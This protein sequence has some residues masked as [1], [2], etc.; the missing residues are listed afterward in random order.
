MGA[1]RTDG[2]GED[3]RLI[4]TLSDTLQNAGVGLNQ[5]IVD[6]YMELV[7]NYGLPAVLAGIQSAVENNKQH[8]F[9]Y[10]AACVA[11]AATGNRPVFAPPNGA[12]PTPPP[13]ER[14]LDFNWEDV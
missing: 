9:K 5:I 12:A 6:Q 14:V 8:R 1:A 4:K 10:V 11:N 2:G 13:A 7:A 3:R